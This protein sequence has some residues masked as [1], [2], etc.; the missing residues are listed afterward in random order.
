MEENSIDDSMELDMSFDAQDIELEDEIDS[1][2]QDYE[3]DFKT[4]R[5]RFCFLLD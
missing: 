5:N 3:E 4:T 2:E 1:F